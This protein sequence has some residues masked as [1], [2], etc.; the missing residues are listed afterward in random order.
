MGKVYTNILQPRLITYVEETNNIS[1]NQAAF[2]PGKSTSDHL[3][4]IKSLVNRYL[5]VLKKDLY[6][7]FVDL[8]KAFDSILAYS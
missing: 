4:V 6:C 7:C 8:T 2:R 1:E 3:F 5:K